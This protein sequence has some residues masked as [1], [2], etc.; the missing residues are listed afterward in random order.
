[1]ENDPNKTELIGRSKDGK[2]AA[3]NTLSRGERVPY[4]QKIHHHGHR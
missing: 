1:M 4:H 3:G 2:F